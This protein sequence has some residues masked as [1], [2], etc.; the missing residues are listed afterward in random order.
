MGNNPIPV[1]V[2]FGPTASGKTSLAGRLFST[3]AS[4]V[5]AGA[6]E[7]VSADSMQV[8]KGMDIG[9]AKADSAFT[10]KL[11]HHLLDICTPDVQ[12]NVAD[13]V[14]KADAACEDI[15]NRGKL[16]VVLGGSSFYIKSFVYG[17][18]VTPESNPDVRLRLQKEL[19]ACG[20]AYMHKKLSEVDPERAAFVHENDEYRI[21][22]ALEIFES[23]GFPLSHFASSSTPRSKYCF[24]IIGL[25]RSRDIL[26]ERINLRVKEM[27][28]AGLTSEFKSLYEKGYTRLDPGM[29]AIGYREYFLAADKLNCMPTEVDDSIVENMIAH[30]SRKYAKKQFTFF[31]SVKET[32]WVNADDENKITQILTDAFKDFRFTGQY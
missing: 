32:V 1:F 27:M 13:F 28:Q 20:A 14:E 22:R 15:F 16:P 29:Q 4:S 10:A 24:C 7:V 6:A 9:T 3:D 5:Y 19:K 23:T 17:L 31:K 25:N 21:L 26:Y 12:F 8:Y 2:V 11:P 30:D 18:P